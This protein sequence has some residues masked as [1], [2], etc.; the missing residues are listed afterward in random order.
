M[1]AR[2]YLR[3]VTIYSTRARGDGTFYVDY[4]RRDAR[5]KLIEIGPQRFFYETGDGPVDKIPPE[6][7]KLTIDALADYYTQ[8]T[9]GRAWKA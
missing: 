8:L 7:Q 2:R 3:P 4:M 5:P 6:Y 9:G 1:P